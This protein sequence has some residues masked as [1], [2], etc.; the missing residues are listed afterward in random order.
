MRKFK[1]GWERTEPGP[2]GQWWTWWARSGGDGVLRKPWALAFCRL[3]RSVWP[4]HLQNEV[5][6]DV[7]QVVMPGSQNSPQSIAGLMNAANGRKQV[8]KLRGIE[9]SRAV[10]RTHAASHGQLAKVRRPLDGLS[11]TFYCS[12]R[13][14]HCPS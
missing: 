12:I 11:K 5:E 9:L 14:M 10:T 13:S 6:A 4:G 1:T 2:A 8:G 7:L 3:R